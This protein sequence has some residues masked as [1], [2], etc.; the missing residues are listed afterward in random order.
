MKFNLTF[1]AFAV[2]C[3]LFGCDNKTAVD[4][5]TIDKQ[6]AT[7]AEQTINKKDQQNAT[8]TTEQ[9]SVA[10]KQLF[11]DSFEASLRL[12]PIEA[13]AIG[14][15]RFD[16]QFPNYYSKAY[17][18]KGHDYT[19]K[20]LAEIK[21]IDRNLLSRKDRISY[22]IFVYNFELDLEGEQYPGELIPISQKANIASFI[23]RLGSGK[24]LH[25]FKTVKNYEDFLKRIDGAVVILNQ[26]SI[27]MDEGIEKGVVQPKALMQ[28]VLPQL[29]AHVVDSVEKSIFYSPIKNLPADF[30]EQDKARLTEA[31]TNAI[32]QKIVPAY[33]KL[34]D[35][36]DRDY[37]KYTRDTFGIGALP[38]G[39]NWYNHRIK[40]QTTTSMTAE[41][42]HAYGLIEVDRIHA[43][44]HQVMKD[45]GFEGNLSEWFEYVKTD[46]KFYFDNEEDILQGYRDLQVKV[47]K[48][49]PKLFDIA[50]KADYEVRPVEAFRAESAAGASYQSGTPDGSRPGIF[51][52]NTFNL[53]SQPNFGMETLSIH[54][55]AP[56]HHFQISIQQEIEGMPKFRRFG[57]F[58]A[59][60]EGWALYAESLGKEM[61]MFTDPMQYYGRLSD[62][63]LR[64]MR[65][66]V[67][68][69]LHAK[70]WGRQQTIDYMLQN[71]S[72]ADTDVVSEVER[73]IARPGQ[74]LGYKI[75]QKII[76]ELRTEAEKTLGD[77]FN[78]KDFHRE[79][80]IDGAVPMEVLKVKVREWITAQQ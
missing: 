8:Q 58:N 80:L 67:D 10:L 4:T 25:P 74:A 61:G 20:W 21:T 73:Y 72:M 50:P 76:R 12:D 33:K 75:G 18:K 13:T 56:G 60:M 32:M 71:S 64:A 39:V 69:G 41:E 30:S 24:S 38:N 34:H 66:V 14:D 3:G 11:A 19:V 9:A 77:K 2:S 42:I 23:A 59:F 57:G 54:E 45:V 22:D 15:D 63:M 6:A 5:N 79:I 53:K 78:I 55:A 70:G 52:V 40:T 48:L 44:M 49:L 28:K 26:A 1:L 43:E 36:I 51:Y 65:L 17:I 46:S 37:L 62:E 16:H 27:N 29:S 47:N 35:Y 68:T 7:A 31:Y